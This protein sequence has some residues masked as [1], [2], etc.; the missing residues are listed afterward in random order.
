MEGRFDTDDFESLLKEQADRFFLVPSERVWKGIYNGLH[1]GSKWPSLG[2][3]LVILISLV[4]IGGSHQSAP[5]NTVSPG[6]TKNIIANTTPVVQDRASIL[7]NEDNVQSAGGNSV[8]VQ[9]S[10]ALSLTPVLREEAPKGAGALAAKQKALEIPSLPAVDLV[11][12]VENTKAVEMQKTDFTQLVKTEESVPV[13]QTSEEKVHNAP[14]E[15]MKPVPTSEKPVMNL[16]SDDLTEETLPELSEFKKQEFIKLI[17]QATLAAQQANAA[18]SL[19]RSS[20]VK[21]AHWEF[22]VAPLISNVR[23]ERKEVEAPPV[24]SFAG[25]TPTPA[26]EMSTRS[27]VGVQAGADALYKINDGLSFRTGAHLTYSGYKVKADFVHPT[28]ASVIFVDGTGEQ[29]SKSYM[30]YYGNKGSEGKTNLNNYS[31]AFSVPFGIDWTIYENNNVQI[32]LMSSVEPMGL[33]KGNAYILSEDGRNYVED[34]DLLRR[35]NINGNV[36]SFI[37]INSSKVNWKMGPVFSYQV[38]SS[39]QNAY[40][41]KEHRINYG[42]R[43][44]VGKRH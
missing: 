28:F 7:F 17:T 18:P 4:W 10:S 42:F 19:K 34:L 27:M 33:L 25:N 39:Y 36:G 20:K 44:G 12:K 41:V 11:Q 21:K 22:F 2:M 15:A 30:T 31:F 40:P 23:F 37:S 8:A 5:E 1:P 3:G 9:E 38:L 35:F 16:Q 24:L 43:L 26:R 6:I 14:V 29:Y 13:I 32:I